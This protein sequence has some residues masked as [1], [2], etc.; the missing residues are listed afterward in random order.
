MAD[1]TWVYFSVAVVLHVPKKS[2]GTVQIFVC[3]VT[4][5]KESCSKQASRRFWLTLTLGMAQGWFL[6]TDFQADVLYRVQK[7]YAK[8]LTGKLLLWLAGSSQGS[9]RHQHIFPQ[10]CWIGLPSCYRH[11]QLAHKLAAGHLG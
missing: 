8:A 11:Q 2:T 10:K 7:E 6:I 4:I 1:R 5:K 3:L 9:K